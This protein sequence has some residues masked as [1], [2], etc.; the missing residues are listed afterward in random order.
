MST[1]EILY[2]ISMICFVIAGI[3]FVLA[4][5]F[6][7]FFR[8][9]TVIGDLSGRTARKAIARIRAHNEKVGGKGYQP[10]ATNAERGKLTS[11][12]QHSRKLV[13]DKPADTGAKAN[14]AAKAPK[15]DAEQRPETGMLKENLAPVERDIP[16]TMH[17]EEELNTAP[18]DEEGTASLLGDEG[19]TELM[20]SN[21]SEPAKVVNRTAGRKM[22]MLDTVMLIHTDEVIP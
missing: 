20:N 6:W 7:F 16:E 1:A 15:Q 14:T 5:F 21:I 10:S 2:L 3:S 4:V 11:T 8:I 9:P 13:P 22:V 19:D 17:L 18:L 12:M